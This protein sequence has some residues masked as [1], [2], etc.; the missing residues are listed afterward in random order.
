MS[1]SRM[2]PQFHLY[3][4]GDGANEKVVGDVPTLTAIDDSDFHGFTD[5]VSPPGI[6]TYVVY[7]KYKPLL[8]DGSVLVACEIYAL[9]RNRAE[10]LFRTSSPQQSSPLTNASI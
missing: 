3:F 7:E 1:F 6:T 2:A 8:I 5:V 10:R 4:V 9:K